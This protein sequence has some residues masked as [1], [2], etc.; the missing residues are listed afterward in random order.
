VAALLARVEAFK[1]DVVHV[2]CVD[3]LRPA[4]VRELRSRVRFVSGQIAAPV[5]NWVDLK[6]YDLLISSLPNFVQR[7]RREGVD[8]EWLPLAFEPLIS[9]TVRHERDTS[10]SF[11]G[12]LS[13]A[14]GDRIEMLEHVADSVPIDV[15]SADLR[16]LS[17]KSPLRRHGHG[18]AWGIDMYRVL[19][20]SRITINH[21]ID[22]ADGY[23]NNLRLYE[24]TGMGCL[25]VT[26][27]GRNLGDLFEV[28]REVVTYG[29]ARECR[30]V[31]AYYVDHPEEADE[32]AAAGRARTLRDHT[33]D[34]RMA[35][36]STLLASRLS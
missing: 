27:A 24:A 7:F 18:S 29:D 12:S 36:L 8:A 20:R 14:H 16:R 31:V 1:P 5:P 23:A 34:D 17:A 4:A 10:V 3:G 28:G 19:A 11:V 21:H 32:I 30:D 33:W 2:Q 26:D 6:A 22:V 15:W 35:R 25:L 9:R 13:P